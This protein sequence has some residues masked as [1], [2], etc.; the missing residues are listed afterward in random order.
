VGTEP[1]SAVILVVDDDDGIREVVE[2]FLREEGYNT[3]GVASTDQAMRILMEEQP[4]L[5]LLDLTTPGMDPGELVKAYRQLS[6][7]TAPIVVVSGR[8]DASQVAE[9]LGAFRSLTKPFDLIV[10]LDTVEEAINSKIS[11]PRT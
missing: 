4:L 2:T 3:R 6:N 8:H 9:C 1:E 11:C 5:I 7:G 10:L